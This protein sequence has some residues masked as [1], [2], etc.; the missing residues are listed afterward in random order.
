MSDDVENNGDEAA[1]SPADGPR[2]GERLANARRELKISIQEI[3]KELHL[4]ERKVRALERNEFDVLGP[5]VFAKGHLRKY[6]ELVDVRV[7][8]VIGDY[9]EMTRAA[10]MPPVVSKRPKPRRELSPG[11]WIAVI[12]V[13][14]ATVTAYFWFTR[15]GAPEPVAADPEAVPGII[16]PPAMDEAAG[17]E[18]A[19]ADE[20]MGV[21][22]A[23]SAEQPA[24]DAP[25]QQAQPAAEITSS[26]EIADGQMRLLLTYSG[27]CWTEVSDASGRSLFFGLGQDGRTVELSGAEPFNVLFG[28]PGNVGVVVNGEDYSLPPTARPGRPLRLTITGS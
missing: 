13:I 24:A 4:D 5:P 25:P 15:S 6:A 16:V 14:I 12:V 20:E 7:D 21:D 2:G 26:P 3:A 28:N 1:A 22:P 23:Q 17:D 27:D 10:E 9:Y 11:P 19:L 18:A 8:D